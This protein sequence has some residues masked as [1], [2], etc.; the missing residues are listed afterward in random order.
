MQSIIV[1]FLYINIAFML[2]YND[3]FVWSN[4]PP[5]EYFTWWTCPIKH[6]TLWSF[7]LFFILGSPHL[8]MLTPPLPPLYSLRKEPQ[9]K[10]INQWFVNLH[11]LGLYIYFNLLTLT[12]QYLLFIIFSSLWILFNYL[13]E[14]VT[15]IE[16]IT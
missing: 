3:K 9:K 11:Y 14:Y 7:Y 1:L 16:S 12:L 10:F 2:F 5:I 8:L 4:Y 15:C 13:L 6:V